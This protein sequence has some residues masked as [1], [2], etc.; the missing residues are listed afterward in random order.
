VAWSGGGGV[1]HLVDGFH[2]FA[3][4]ERQG[5]E[6]LACICLPEHTPLDQLLQLVFLRKEK[7]ILESAAARARYVRFCR[8]AG[9][10]SEILVKTILPWLE[11]QPHAELLSRLETVAALPKPFLDYCHEK[12]V[13]LKKCS[14]FAR[15]PQEILTEVFSWRD[16]LNLSVGLIEEFATLVHDILRSTP[17]PLDAFLQT[18]DICKAPS[19]D[20]TRALL[21][22]KRFPTWTAQ[23]A[24][25]GAIRDRLRLP[26]SV[27]L[28]WDPSFER[29]EVSVTSTF[30]SMDEWPKVRDAL[31]SPET[32]NT[33]RDILENL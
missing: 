13:P 2:R 28:R 33:L 20:K 23:Q 3:W 11:L 8:E 31:S 16:R 15:M 21:R 14:T 9:A 5:K 7:V 12:R 29:K 1:F 26:P 24:K 32:E 19:I 30:R 27:D 18:T 25:I 10:S 17:M 22:A 4:L 6:S